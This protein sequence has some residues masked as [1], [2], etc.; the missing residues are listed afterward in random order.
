MSLRTDMLNQRKIRK[1]ALLLIYAMEI[2][3]VVPEAQEV[4]PFD[5]FWMLISENDA[6]RYAKALA[7]AVL[8]ETRSLGELEEML[9]H[10]TEAFR[11]A[12]AVQPKLQTLQSS[13]QEL[14]RSLPM[15]RDDTRYLHRHLEVVANEREIEEL[16]SHSSSAIRI[17]GRM[18]ELTQHILS[19]L[20]GETREAVEAYAGVLRRVQKATAGCAQLTHPQQSGSCNEHANLARYTEDMRNRRPL[21]EQ[22]A[23]DIYARRAEWE[24]LLH[25]L[26]RNYVPERLNAIDRCILYIAFYDLMQRRLDLGSLFSRR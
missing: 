15:L 13:S 14:L 22:Y 12:A 23:R 9:E 7:K 10:R 1:S 8:H 25:A 4:F 2:Q 11:T 3:G 18:C 21:T 19:L 20:K 24:K 17:C 26:L 6:L 16:Q 5:L